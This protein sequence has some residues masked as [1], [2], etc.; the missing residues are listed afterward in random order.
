MSNGFFVN[1][2]NGVTIKN[3]YVYKT[4]QSAVQWVGAGRGTGAGSFIEDNWF[5][6]TGG[7]GNPSILLIDTSGVTVRRNK[8]TLDP[9]TK[10]GT[11]LRIRNCGD[12]S[13][14]FLDNNNGLVRI[15][16]TTAGCPG[17]SLRRD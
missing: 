4:G 16:V 2:V 5:D 6:A 11:D 1:S 10:F 8:F 14:V 13:N 17:A 15:A 9:N 12:T 3:N 7:G